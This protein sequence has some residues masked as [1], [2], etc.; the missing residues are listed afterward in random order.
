MYCV[1]LHILLL[2]FSIACF[3]YP[4]IKNVSILMTMRQTFCLKKIVLMWW[5]NH[6]DKINQCQVAT[7]IINTFIECLCR[8]VSKDCCEYESLTSHLFCF[9]NVHAFHPNLVICCILCMIIFKIKLK[10]LSRKSSIYISYITAVVVK[11]LK[12]HNINLFCFTSS[13]ELNTHFYVCIIF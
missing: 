6:C 3:T 10:V 4:A 7:L 12:T 8:N 11:F 1:S 2:S 5:G 9:A 13:Y